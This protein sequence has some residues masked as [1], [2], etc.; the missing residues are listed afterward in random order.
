MSSQCHC[1][2]LDSVNHDARDKSLIG[3]SLIF[4]INFVRN[5]FP[6]VLSLAGNYYNYIHLP[7]NKF[8]S[9]WNS[10]YHQTKFISGRM[11]VMMATIVVCFI[12]MWESWSWY[13]NCH[14]IGPHFSSHKLYQQWNIKTEPETPFFLL[15]VKLWTIF[16]FSTFV[17]SY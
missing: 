9:W 7:S 1:W 6:I 16:N 12:T 4:I 15:N 17:E 11:V 14:H 3:F 2:C 5:N 13:K 8:L 10:F